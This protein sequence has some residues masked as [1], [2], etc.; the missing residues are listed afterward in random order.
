MAWAQNWELGAAGVYSYY[1]NATI[2]TSNP[3]G[4]ATAGFDSAGGF[5]ASFGE[6]LYNH[7][8]G[9]FRY[10]FLLN[11]LKLSGNG[12]SV[13]RDAHEHA[14]H[15]DVLFYAKGRNARIRPF[16]A[17]GGGIRLFSG[18]GVEQAA[19]PLNRFAAL[20]HTN[21]L[22]PLVSAGGGVL[23]KISKHALFRVDFRDYISPIPESVISPAPGARLKGV[24][25]DF[26]GFG[27]VS[28]TF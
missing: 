7:V 22:K 13:T 25:N 18:T 28:Y 27:G 26:V 24:L 14:V 15:Y 10:T 11:K 6:Q 3:A 16:L 12:Q 4:S 19:Q 2:T 17:G 9:E 8:G 20:T 1:K 5:S 21:Q 23:F